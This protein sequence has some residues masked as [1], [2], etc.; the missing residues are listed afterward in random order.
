MERSRQHGCGVEPGH[1]VG[2]SLIVHRRPLQREQSG[3]EEDSQEE[4]G[5]QQEVAVGD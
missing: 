5:P 4:A 1:S 3:S 2:H